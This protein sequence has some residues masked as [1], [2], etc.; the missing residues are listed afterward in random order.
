MSFQDQSQ[1]ICKNFITVET[2]SI[3]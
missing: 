3:S 2:W 1:N